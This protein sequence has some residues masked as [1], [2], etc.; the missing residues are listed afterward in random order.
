GAVSALLSAGLLFVVLGI[1]WRSYRGATQGA[2][3]RVIAIGRL[4]GGAGAWGLRFTQ[5]VAP[6]APRG[7]PGARAR[8]RLDRPPALGPIPIA[9]EGDR[10]R[11]VET[12][13]PKSKPGRRAAAAAQPTLDLIPSEEYSLPPLDLLAKPT[14]AAAAQRINEESLEKNA[15]LLE[16]VL[17]DFG[18]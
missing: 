11:L 12:T 3:D 1:P 7:R 5:R 6:T 15:R 14:T 4:G 2:A 9:P 8:P 17:D 18:V 10:A 16:S 13:R